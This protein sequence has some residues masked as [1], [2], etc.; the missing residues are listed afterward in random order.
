[1]RLAL[2]LVVGGEEIWAGTT[3]GEASSS[4]RD[5]GTVVEHLRTAVSEAISKARPGIQ[6]ALR[7]ADR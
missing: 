3:R 1:M 2:Y 7:R 6:Q 5:V 4:T